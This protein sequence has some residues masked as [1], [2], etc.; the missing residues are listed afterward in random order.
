MCEFGIMKHNMKKP[1]PPLPPPSS[2]HKRYNNKKYRGNTISRK[3]SAQTFV[4]VLVIAKRC[5]TRKCIHKYMRYFYEL[6][7]DVIKRKNL[8][9]NITNIQNMIKI[10]F[11]P[12]MYRILVIFSISNACFYSFFSTCVQFKGFQWMVR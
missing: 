9:E 1:P 6:L 2:C 10:V 8:T 12:F 3:T 7:L 11:H 4:R 5:I